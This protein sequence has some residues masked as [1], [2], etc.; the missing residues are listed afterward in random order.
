MIGPVPDD[1]RVQPRAD[2]VEQAAPFLPQGSQIRQAFI[3]QTAPR[4]AYFL[5]PY[6]T[7]LTV[8]A[9]KY[10][11]VAI[12]R[13]T[14]YVLESNKRSGGARPE[15][16]AGTLQRKT[17]IGPVSGRWAEIHLLGERR[18]VHQRFHPQIDAADEEAG[19]T[20]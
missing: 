6:L 13:D 7:G 15:S 20:R 5:L 16:L 2:L 8:A 18:W 17:R 11:C 3:C 14:I 12:T 4:F 9:I 1:A 19:F 10:H